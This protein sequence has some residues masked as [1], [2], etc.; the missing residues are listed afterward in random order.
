MILI[1]MVKMEEIF[2]LHS[3]HTQIGSCMKYCVFEEKLFASSDV[4]F[5]HV[6]SEYATQKQT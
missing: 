1:N 2:S 4:F 5:Y 6:S 3:V